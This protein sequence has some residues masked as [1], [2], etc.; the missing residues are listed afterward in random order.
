MSDALRKVCALL[1]NPT[2]S[3]DV[4]ACGRCVAWDIA[5]GR[6][7][8]EDDIVPSAVWF[9]LPRAIQCDACAARCESIEFAQDSVRWSLRPSIEARGYAAAT[10]AHILSV[11]LM[12]GGIAGALDRTL[13]D[14]I[15]AHVA[16]DP[17]AASVALDL[18]EER[19]LDAGLWSAVEVD[20]PV[21]DE[22][23]TGDNPHVWLPVKRE[24]D[25]H[26][27]TSPVWRRCPCGLYHDGDREVPDRDSPPAP[28]LGGLP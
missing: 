22:H 4:A 28:S 15:A 27:W 7:T 17:A 5:T 1:N 24:H 2:P 23:G 21:R 6:Y 11:S 18:A 26:R 3:I 16:G 25:G 14:L 19:G 13:A 10:H 8:V 20:W 9:C 12:L